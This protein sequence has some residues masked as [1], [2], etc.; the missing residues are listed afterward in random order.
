MLTIELLID[1]DDIEMLR[2]IQKVTDYPK[3][4]TTDAELLQIQ[5]DYLMANLHDEWIQE[6]LENDTAE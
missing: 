2:F 1:E 5:V 6:K 4:P 3:E